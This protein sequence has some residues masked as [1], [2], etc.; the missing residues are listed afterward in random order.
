VR[1][2][3][4]LAPLLA[5]ALAVTAVV[6]ARPGIVA[7]GQA[8][9]VDA[10]ELG[11]LSAL[12]GVHETG[13]VEENERGYLASP[14]RTAAVSVPVPMPAPGQGRGVLHL[15]AYGLPGASTTVRLRFPNGQS[16]LLGR[17]SSWHGRSFDLS[18]V[19]RRG[20]R[21]EA[22]M[23]NPE[24]RPALFLDRVAVE[25]LPASARTSASPGAVAALVGLAALALLALTG[26]ARRHWPLAVLLGGSAALL[27]SQIPKRE[28]DPLSPDAQS[29]WGAATHASW[30]GFHDGLLWGSWERLSSLTVEVFH[31]LTPLVGTAAVSAR[32]A[33]V[34]A[35]VLALAAVY[36]LGNRA[37]GRVGAVVATLVAMAAGPFRHAA[38][39][40]SSLPVLLLA[41]ALFGYALHA[42]VAE[43]SRPAM[44]LLGA[45][46]ALLTLA[47]PVFLP[48]A[49]GVMAIVSYACAPADGRA[50][51]LA[52]GALALVA[53]LLPHLMS[54]ADQNANHPFADMSARAT[55]ARNV[56]FTGAG[57]GA[58]T[59]TELVRDPYGGRPA[60][61][62]GYLFGDHSL[63]DLAGG[64]IAGVV[65]SVTAFSSS[66]P[67][68]LA[69]VLMLAG[70]LY[71]L[72][73]PRLRLLV[74]LP[75]LAAAPALFLVH[76]HGLPKLAGGAVMWP[77]LTAAAGV[78][79]YALAQLARPALVRAAVGIRG[80]TA[81][82]RAR[83]S[84]R[85]ALEGLGEER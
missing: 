8:T 48:G 11:R 15:W 84:G 3:R 24:A 10:L 26:R 6:L 19:P 77:A 30:F 29:T 4:W 1:A 62:P 58:P 18:G 65:P 52:A 7:S 64:T 53:L 22:R 69:F 61:L 35:A 85:M 51:A 49:I 43:A 31:A 12:Q 39:D 2:L 37:G 55:Y 83:L 5:V 27:W 67:A 20:V 9:N 44:L 74:L 81:R 14:R 59:L 47:E 82:A 38:V 56:E 17:A 76:E 13:G 41:G 42:C 68:R 34:F 21:L 75:V 28:L 80:S 54:T 25:A 46:T 72:V 40:G 23:T 50:R 73:V 33:G 45:A 36:A 66:G 78:L 57:H 16:R 60:T 32:S 71:L 70:A 63:P 79:A